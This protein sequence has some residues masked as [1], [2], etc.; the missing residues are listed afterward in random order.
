MRITVVRLPGDKLS[1]SA[2]VN[3]LATQQNVGV[4]IGKAYI[5]D[6]M[7]YNEYNIVFPYRNVIYP[8]REVSVY[9]HT[10]GESFVAIVTSI[11]I[12]ITN[13]DGV[14]LILTTLVVRRLK[15]NA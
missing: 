2:I 1:P 15:P 4:D 8:G 13:E 5:Y 10:L 12:D 9:D 14:N 11:N 3:A 6:S 7:T